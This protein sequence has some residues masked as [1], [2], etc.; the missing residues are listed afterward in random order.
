MN[1]IRIQEERFMPYLENLFSLQG[2]VALVTGSTR[3]LGRAMARIGA[4]AREQSADEGRKDAHMRNT[5]NVVGH[6]PAQSGPVQS[7]FGR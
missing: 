3:G 2:K 7:S 1:P 5:E 6:S 4:R